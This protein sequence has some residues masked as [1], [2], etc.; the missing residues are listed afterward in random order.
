MK[1]LLFLLLIAS[2]GH[3]AFAQRARP[4]A[5]PLQGPARPP[6]PPIRN[7]AIGDRLP[8]E[9]MM[10]MAVDGPPSSLNQAATE[11]GLLVMFSCNTCPYVIKAQPR[12]AEAIM[13]ARKFGLGMIIINSNEAQRQSEDSYEAMKLYAKQHDYTCPYVIDDNSTMADLFGA[14][15]TPEV[16]LFDA[17]RKL[18]YK[19]ALE[20]NPSEPEK[21][22]E[23]Y[24]INA[25]RALHD[26]KPIKVATTKSIG[27][28][29][30]RRS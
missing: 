19:G 7:L 21:S 15:R 1:K 23:F 16:F 28:S 5:P 12:T 17:E 18:V 11:K 27:C 9:G 25:M 30:K 3:V 4:G 8:N 20:D 24:L 13:F 10:M 22:K 29:I 26:N 6:A 14:T 2:T